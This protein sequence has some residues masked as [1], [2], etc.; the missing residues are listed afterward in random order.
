LATDVARLAQQKFLAFQSGIAQY[1]QA[2]VP[3]WQAQA[4]LVAELGCSRLLDYGGEGEVILLIP[5]LINKAN[6]L[7]LSPDLSFAK[8]LSKGAHVFMLDWGVP[9]EVEANFA[10]EDYANRIAEFANNINQPFHLAGYCMGGLIALQAAPK[11][12][13][14]S[15]ILLATPWNFAYLQNKAKYFA[16]MAE[17]IPANFVPPEILQNL[18]FTIDPWR[19]FKKFSALPTKPKAVQEKFFLIEKW[20]NDGVPMPKKLFTQA[21]DD[22]I[23]KNDKGFDLKKI[24]IPVFAV[25]PKHDKIVPLSASLAVADDLQ[26]CK[27]KEYDSGHIGLVTKDIIY[28]DI[29]AWIN[30]QNKI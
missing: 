16:K 29:F 12:S 18:F 30:S 1:L 28:D 9:S 7:D 24:T 22:W 14:K 15:I 3:D 11:L 6:I 17:K 13:L 8:K 20:A 26:D 4:Q 10:S 21:I 23:G 5:P 25:C 27:I 19:V 2:Q